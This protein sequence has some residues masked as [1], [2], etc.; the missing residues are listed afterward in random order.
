MMHVFEHDYVEAI[1]AC[2]KAFI[3]NSAKACI[4]SISLMVSNPAWQKSFVD[5]SEERS[6]I[7]NAIL[8]CQNYP[9]DQKKSCVDGAI[10]NILNFDHLDLA[11]S[12]Q[13]CQG[14]DQK[15]QSLCY[16]QI[17]LNLGNIVSNKSA[18]QDACATLK[19]EGQKICL[20]LWI[21]R[22]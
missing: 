13:F 18:A 20:S 15:Y 14:I 21:N 11:R 7:E 22:N 2:R 16:K 17:S 5:N 12:E 9:E 19:S 8:I 1:N 6:M 3:E 10:S 4:S